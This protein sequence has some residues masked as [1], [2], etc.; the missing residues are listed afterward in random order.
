MSTITPW[1]A[2]TRVRPK[3]IE[4]LLGHL[5]VAEG[6]LLGKPSTMVDPGEAVRWYREAVDQRHFRVDAGSVEQML[7][8]LLL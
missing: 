7:S 6:A 4:G 1:P 8:E 2:D 3:P 5:L